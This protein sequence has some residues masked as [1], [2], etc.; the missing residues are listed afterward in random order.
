MGLL[1]ASEAMPVSAIWEV[2]DLCLGSPRA[3][4]SSVHY[5]L[6]A[7]LAAR[8]PSTS[9]KKCSELNFFTPVRGPG[10][11]RDILKPDSI[12]MSFTQET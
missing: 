9:V 8:G 7:C 10:P 4:C 12:S 1:P 2:G 3:T 5:A 6:R 11:K